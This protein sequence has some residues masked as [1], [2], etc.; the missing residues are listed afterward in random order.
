MVR[1]G[2]Q[3]HREHKS[4]IPSLVGGWFKYAKRQIGS[5]PPGI[6]V[7]MLKIY[8]SCHHLESEAIR[9]DEK[10]CHMHLDNNFGIYVFD[11]QEYV[12]LHMN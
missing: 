9:F 1:E 5:F 11:Q 4:L 3:V 10:K 6:G 7:K 2:W 8:L 12:E